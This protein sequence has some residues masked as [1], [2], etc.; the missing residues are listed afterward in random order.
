MSLA[1]NAT[2]WSVLYL[3]ENCYRHFGSNCDGNIVA[4]INST[5]NIIQPNNVGY[6]LYGYV[7][8][9]IYIYYILQNM[10]PIVIPVDSYLIELQK[11]RKFIMLRLKNLLSGI[12]RKFFSDTVGIK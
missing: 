2:E 3:N 7:I 11:N 9:K 10:L 5:N 12:N 6:G 1:N 8:K 4:N